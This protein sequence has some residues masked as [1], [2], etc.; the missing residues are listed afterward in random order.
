MLHR[1]AGPIPAA[2][3]RHVAVKN[4]DRAELDFPRTRKQAKQGRLA[5]AV[6]ADLAGSASMSIS[7][8]IQLDQHAVTGLRVDEHDPTVM[9][10]RLR[11]IMTS[12]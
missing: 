8:L 1:I 11:R 12:K 7:R 5:D 2:A 4:F 10:S 3:A 9:R 6:G